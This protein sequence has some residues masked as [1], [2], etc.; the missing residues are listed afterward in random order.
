MQLKERKMGRDINVKA[1]EDT[2][3]LCR[4]NYH[5]SRSIESSISLQKVIKESNHVKVPVVDP[6]SLRAKVIVSD[7]R[8]LEALQAYLPNCYSYDYGH[9]AVLNSTWD[10][11]G[12]RVSKGE[13]GLQESLCRCTTLKPCLDACEE[14]F[15]RSKGRF[16]N[17]LFNNDVILT[18]KV[19]VMKEDG[20][21]CRIMHEED[22]FDID[23]I[24]C[25]PPD[26][27]SKMSTNRYEKP[28][29][30]KDLSEEILT[31]I[32]EKRFRRMLDVALASGCDY[33]VIGAL[34]CGRAKNPAGVVAQAA[35][36]AVR[37]Y[38]YAFKRI[39]FAVHDEA[40]NRVF[41]TFQK[42]IYGTLS[43][44]GIP[45]ADQVKD[46]LLYDHLIAL[47]KAYNYAVNDP[48]ITKLAVYGIE[49]YELSVIVWIK[50]P[51]A[52]NCS[53]IGSKIYGLGVF[54]YVI[55]DPTHRAGNASYENRGLVIYD[56]SRPT[57][58]TD[59]GGTG[60][61]KE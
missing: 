49:D 24:S 40:D 20:Y 4:D 57:S 1:F 35:A 51:T 6:D 41:R 60:K 8:T 52:K 27:T 29:S 14:S 43:N 16:E 31:G 13:T 42:I 25:I 12:G 5:L 56:S 2:L 22:W 34:G 10:N 55:G 38:L 44:T 53:R 30:I 32:I 54:P 36:N 58:E 19:T 3:K 37:D 33:I 46:Y 50:K 39:I 15:Y 48:Q 9:A 18:P 11:P 17:P 28:I 61:N 7:L 59:G 45:D 47:K 23:V 26:L 21:D